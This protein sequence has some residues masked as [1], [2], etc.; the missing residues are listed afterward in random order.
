M[1][2]FAHT[3]NLVVTQ[4]IEANDLLK[5]L[6][7]KCRETVGFF[8]RSNEA[9]RRLA[10]LSSSSC[11]KLKQEVPT[12]WN[13]TYFMLQSL[14]SLRDG[15]YSTLTLLKRDDL[16]FSDE[17]WELIAG[18]VELLRPFEEVTR[19]LS[20]SSYPSMSKMI[21]AVRLLQR[22][23]QHAQYTFNGALEQLRMDLINSVNSRFRLVEESTVPLVS[24]FLDPR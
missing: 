14:L 15:V 17:D 13:S 22:H 5:P 6:F 23:L 7:A 3:L 2:C 24:T 18:S 11:K 10:Q 9:A 12:R 1:S 20:S 19:D 16:K 8:K 21:P 4:S